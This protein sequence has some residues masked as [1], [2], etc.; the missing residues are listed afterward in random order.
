M[1]SGRTYKTM[2]CKCCNEPVDKVDIKATAVTCW[3]CSM[4]GADS[5]VTKK[6]HDQIIK[7]KEPKENK[8]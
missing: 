7:D 2:N 4:K 8:Q 5:V 3:R 6:E 1:S